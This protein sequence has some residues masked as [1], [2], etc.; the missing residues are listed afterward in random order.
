MNFSISLLLAG[1]QKL[2][3]SRTHTGTVWLGWHFKVHGGAGVDTNRTQSDIFHW[4]LLRLVWLESMP[5]LPYISTLSKKKWHSPH[6][7]RPSLRLARKRSAPLTP[8]YLTH[9]GTRLAL[10]VAR[11]V[12]WRRGQWR[13]RVRWPHCH[14]HCAQSSARAPL[15]HSAHARTRIHWLCNKYYAWS[16]TGNTLQRRRCEQHSCRTAS[17]PLRGAWEGV[18]RPQQQMDAE[19]VIRQKSKATWRNVLPASPVWCDVLRDACV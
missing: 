17:P 14:L 11:A 2:W 8:T 9:S 13:R 10:P 3:H 4:Y 1:A 15:R 12:P 19:K 16:K 18:F 7:G 5:V 6:F